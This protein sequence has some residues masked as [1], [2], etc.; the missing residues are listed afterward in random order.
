MNKHF[1]TCHTEE[2]PKHPKHHNEGC[3]PCIE[4]NLKLGEIPA[5]FWQN[6]ANVKGETQWSAEHFAGFVLEQRANT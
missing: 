2:C 5:C 6:V 1:C 4:K 3:D